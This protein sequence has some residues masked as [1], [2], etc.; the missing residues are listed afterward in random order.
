MQEDRCRL[1]FLVLAAVL[2][3]T[4]S[5]PGYLSMP[6][7]PIAHKVAAADCAVLGKITAIQDKPVEGQV[8]RYSTAPR[9]E[10]TLVEVNVQESLYGASDMKQV[11]F[12]FRDIKAYKPRLTIGQRGYFCGVKVGMND[13][14]H[15]PLRMLL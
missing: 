1:A 5:A 6:R 14:F 11:R 8:W 7:E 12:G 2:G 9:W 10:F 13:F 3:G 4:G 15:R